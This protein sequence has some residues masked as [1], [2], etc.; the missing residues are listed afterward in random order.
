MDLRDVLTAVALAASLWALL[1]SY[2]VD[3]RDLFLKMHTELLGE[4]PMA[5]RRALSQID[6]DND[7]R[8]SLAKPDEQ[9]AIYRAL[10]LFDVLGL[11]VEE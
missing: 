3:K 5:G 10:A 2:R 8:V 1:R 9:T 6:S 7:A 4:V 11:Y